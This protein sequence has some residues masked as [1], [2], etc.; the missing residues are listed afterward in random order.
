MSAGAG[1]ATP[2]DPAGGGWGGLAAADPAARTRALAGLIAAG[3]AST[4]LLLAALAGGDAEVRARAAQGL[5]EIGDPAAA[6]A[7]AA[8]LADAAPAVRGRAAQ[9]LAALGDPRAVA[10]L[11]QTL[12]D[13]PDLLHAPHSVA[14]YALIARGA[15]VLPAVLPLLDAQVAATRQRAWLVWQTVVQSVVQAMPGVAPAGWPA[16]WRAMGAYAPGAEAAARAA[17][18]DA[19]RRWLAALSPAACGWTP[20]ATRAPAPDW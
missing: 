6:P 4:P 5:A 17:A 2:A 14:T 19:W 3:R 1:S 15:P 9:G 20:P 16:L 11:V 12:D 18:V 10:A 13:L 7:L 8:A